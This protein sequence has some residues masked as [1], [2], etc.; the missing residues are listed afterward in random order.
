MESII[1]ALITGGLAFIGT[2]V[3]NMSAHSK[4]IYRIEQLEKKQ[5]IHNG[6]ISRMYAA[7]KDIGLLQEK[8]KVAN[9]RI[10]DLETFEQAVERSFIH[11]HPPDGVTN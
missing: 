8:Q 11:P 4:T 5:D 7:E 10:G 3:S 1:V 9:R 2:M 6:I